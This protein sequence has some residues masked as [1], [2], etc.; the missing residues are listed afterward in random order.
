MERLSDRVAKVPKSGIRE[1]FD[2]AE[3]MRGVINLGIGEPDFDA[4]KF[5]KSAAETAI[6]AGLGKYTPNAGILELREEIAKKLKHENAVSVDPRSEVVVTSGATQAI[7]VA[8]ACLLNPGDEVLV[9]TPAFPAYRYAANLVGGIC[10]DVPS[11]ESEGFAPDFGALEKACTSRTK[12]LVINS[13]SNPTG[14]VLQK[15]SIERACELAASK[16][17]VLITDEI[18]EKFLYD[19]SSHF[20]AGSLNE[21]HNRIVTIN[22]FAKTYGMTGWRLGYAAGPSEI[23]NAMIRFNMYNAVCATSFVQYAGLKALQHPIAF[24]KPILARY[25][26]KRKIVCDWLDR[27]DWE[28]QKPGGAFYIFPKL[29]EAFRSSSTDFPI[30][31]LQAQRVATIPGPSFGEG[32]RGHIRVSYSLD[33]SSLRASLSRIKRFTEK[34]SAS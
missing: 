25:Q 18:Y 17:L 16:D 9:P 29:P 10:R 1:I 6:K 2:L 23:I 7:F 24:F 11:I 26:E 5:V 4:P 34:N 20:S 33:K 22:G 27:N 12:V 14:A 19:G 32:G 13:P 30:K 3:S 8:M 21:F 28:F 15:R 31:L